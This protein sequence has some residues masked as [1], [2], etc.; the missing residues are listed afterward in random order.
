MKIVPWII[1]A[2]QKNSL[3]LSNPL[4]NATLSAQIQVSYS[5]SVQPRF[6]SQVDSHW[7]TVQF[8]GLLFSDILA[9]NKID[10]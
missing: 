7:T 3:S 2:I 4:P 5:V 8:S 6:E 9:I 1:A 10:K